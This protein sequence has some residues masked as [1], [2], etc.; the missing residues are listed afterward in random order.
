MKI[1]SFSRVVPFEGIPHAGGAYYH[2]HLNHLLTRHDVVIVAPNTPR[3]RSAVER[4][5]SNAEVIL[6]GN[7]NPRIA[8][9]WMLRIQAEL[10]P[11]SAPFEVYRFIR[12]NERLRNILRTADVVE[13]QWSEYSSLIG[14]VNNVNPKAKKI[15]VMHDV[16]QQKYQRRLATDRAFKKRIR[17]LLAY[18]SAMLLEPRRLR[19]CDSI[20]VFSKKD[21]DLLERA[22]TRASI[23][24]V[25]PPLS[26][27]HADG[28]A[29]RDPFSVLFTGAMDR[30]ENDQ[31][32]RWFI[33]KCWPSVRQIHPSATLTIAGAYPT[34]KL[35]ELASQDPS[36]SVTGYVAE[37][38]PYYIKSSLFVVPLFQGAGVKFK[39]I[40][41]M[42]HGLPVISTTVGAEGVGPP[43]LFGAISDEAGEFAL[44]V[45]RVLGDSF[46]WMEISEKS[47]EWASRT[48]GL[49]RFHERLDHAFDFPAEIS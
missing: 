22:R 45:N 48:Y 16:L 28:L 37:L 35:L 42:L 18:V 2:H 32:I 23:V 40:S 24:I 15:V 12:E 47:S 33:E 4:F 11:A 17:A 1:V 43:G 27:A 8:V 30:P 38:E 19:Q 34:E 29:S 13:F 41:A 14:E 20:I 3:N 31:G 5:Q 49:G 44:A 10:R 6:V 36:I 9:K 21:K 25:P 7:E 46:L 39:T 26:I